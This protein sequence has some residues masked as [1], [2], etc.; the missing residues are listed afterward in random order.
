MYVIVWKYKVRPADRSGF[1]VEYGSGGIW[2]SFA[3]GS[4]GYIGSKLYKGK[5]HYYLLIDAW[6]SKDSYENFLAAKRTHYQQLSE[7]FSY[8]FEEGICIG[9]FSEL[10]GVLT[11]IL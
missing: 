10:K 3:K 1:E 11:T 2:V 8:L 5:D 6:D 4:T 9:E 7:Q